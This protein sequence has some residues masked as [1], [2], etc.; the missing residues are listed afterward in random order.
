MNGQ[1]SLFDFIQDPEQGQRETA[2]KWSARKPS[3]KEAEQIGEQMDEGYRAGIPKTSGCYHV[4]EPCRWK[5]SPEDCASCY[6]Y[7]KAGTAKKCANCNHFRKYVAGLH[8]EYHGWACFGFG[9][10]RS[11]G[12]PNKPACRD[13]IP[14]KQDGETG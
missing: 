11:E 9:I 10:D 12:K 14:R 5:K 3:D 13:W 2:E 4:P 7:V 8:E 1:M 6:L